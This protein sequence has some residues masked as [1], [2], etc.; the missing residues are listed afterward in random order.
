MQITRIA[1]LTLAAGVLL[2]PPAEAQGN[3]P[4]PVLVEPGEHAKFSLPSGIGEDVEAACGLENDPLCGVNIEP[5]DKAFTWVIIPIGF[6]KDLSA[7]ITLYKNFVVS[8]GEE[9]VLRATVAG[10]VSWKGELSAIGYGSE[11]EID[12]VAELFDVTAQTVA[13]ATGVFNQVLTTTILDPEGFASPSGDESFSFSANVV[14][15]HEYEIRM[16]AECRART[17]LGNA[18]CGF[19]TGDTGDGFVKWNEFSI[20]VETDQIAMLETILDRQ[21]EIL[22]LLNTPHGRRHTD[23]PACGG[24][25]CEYPE[26][27]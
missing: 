9:R 14:R 6:T 18:A 24:E 26:T 7:A 23:V 21:L 3:D 12:I 13:G 11:A 27:D 10:N 5:P 4:D 15:G 20:S 2:A 1:I 22:R 8:Q 16:V 19:V 25:A 17:D